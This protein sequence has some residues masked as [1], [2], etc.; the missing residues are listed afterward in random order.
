[1]SE[2]WLKRMNMGKTLTKVKLATAIRPIWYKAIQYNTCNPILH[3]RYTLELRIFA[4][5]FP[6]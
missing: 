4:N 3:L 6:K 1:M 5:M 2:N